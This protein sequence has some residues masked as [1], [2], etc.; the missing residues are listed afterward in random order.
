MISVAHRPS[1]IAFHEQI[2]RVTPKVSQ[3]TIQPSHNP[4]TLSPLLL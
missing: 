3:S 2:L 4:T 1:V